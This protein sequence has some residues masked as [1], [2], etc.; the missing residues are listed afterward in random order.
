MVALTRMWKIKVERNGLGGVVLS[1]FAKGEKG[2]RKR[3]SGVS[4]ILSYEQ[5]VRST[6]ITN[7]SPTSSLVPTETKHS[8]CLLSKFVIHEE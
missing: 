1:E 5:F 4:P 7:F 3:T 2:F 6:M 8:K